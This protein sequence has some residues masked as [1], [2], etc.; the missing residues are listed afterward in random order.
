MRYEI[1]LDLKK[2]T[3]K[4]TKDFMWC[5]IKNGYSPYLEWGMD[6]KI[7]VVIEDECVQKIKEV[8]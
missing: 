1:T 3:E 6:G 4:E 2:S 5:L 8:E 7:C